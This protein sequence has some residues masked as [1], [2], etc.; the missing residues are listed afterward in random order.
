MLGEEIGAHGELRISECG[1]HSSGEGPN[2]SGPNREAMG[3][4]Y[5][6][7]IA[8]STHQAGGQIGGPNAGGPRATDF[9]ASDPLT[10]PE[11]EM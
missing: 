1:T 5:G 2:A 11:E 6:F 4:N 3:S 10:H 9:G 7:R 8:A